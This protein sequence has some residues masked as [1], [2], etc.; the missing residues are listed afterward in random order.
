MSWAIWITGLPGSGKSTLA[1]AVAAALAA[2]R[3]SVKLLELDQIRRVLTPAPTYSAGEREIVYRALVYMAKLLTEA[4]IPVIVDATGHRRAWRELAREL[5]PLFAEVQLRC[6]LPVC[7]ERERTR[8][9]RSV[10]SGIYARAGQPGATVPGVD[11]PYEESLCPEAA[12]DTNMLDLR[13]QVQ[14]V[15]YLARHLSR[16]A[17]RRECLPAVRG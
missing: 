15:L 11:L 5:I 9:R 14:E 8:R 6:P 12:L 10:P 2:R 4:G 1:R 7:V 13:T 16:H 3:I 17:A